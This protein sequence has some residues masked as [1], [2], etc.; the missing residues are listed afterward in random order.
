MMADEMV[1]RLRATGNLNFRPGRDLVSWEDD[2]TVR[3]RHVVTGAEER[4]ANVDLVVALVGSIPRS[5]L[6]DT[7]R[8]RVKDL[9]VIGDARE[10]RTVEEATTEGA[11]LGR[12]V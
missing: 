8:G 10:P 11:A 2:S 7:L 9:H 1:H 6:A 12:S 5:S 4:L 3:L